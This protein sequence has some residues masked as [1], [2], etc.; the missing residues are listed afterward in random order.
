[1]K[2]TLTQ[3][4]IDIIDEQCSMRKLTI[5]DLAKQTGISESTFSK[6]RA[7]PNTKLH[8]QQI[9]LISKALGIPTQFFANRYDTQK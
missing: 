1:M 3:C 9:V 8:T 4:V 7:N 2:K 5:R 6:W